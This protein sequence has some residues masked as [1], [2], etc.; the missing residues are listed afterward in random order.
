[1]GNIQQGLISDLDSA[2]RAVIQAAATDKKPGPEVLGPVLGVAPGTLRNM[3]N[4]R[5]ASHHLSVIRAVIAQKRTG[6]RD[7]IETES[8]ALGGIFTQLGD[9]SGVDDVELLTLYTA[10]HADLGE[11][12]DAIHSA[13][14][15]RAIPQDLFNTIHREMYEDI[16]RGF[17]LLARLEAWVDQRVLEAVQ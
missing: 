9:F 15:H 3:L 10:Y 17:E 1:M 2:Q 13:L 11:T 12:A 8:R 16:Q 4:E 6:R 14:Q 7:I 5:Q